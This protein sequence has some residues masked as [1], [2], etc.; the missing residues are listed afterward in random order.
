MQGDALLVLLLRART[1]PAPWTLGLVRSGT[2][3][4]SGVCRA[5]TAGSRRQADNAWGVHRKTGV[6]RGEQ[7]RAAQSRQGS[8]EKH[9]AGSA[10]QHRAGSTEQAASVRDL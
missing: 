10:G 6:Q 1:S 2:L 8:T 4:S 7:S 9:R 3:A 5:G